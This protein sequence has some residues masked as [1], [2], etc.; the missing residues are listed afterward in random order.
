MYYYI[1]T[2]V[3]VNMSHSTDESLHLILLAKI[4]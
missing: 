3:F 2:D 4:I 1:L